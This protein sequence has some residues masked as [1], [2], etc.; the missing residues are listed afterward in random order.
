M[1]SG[2]TAMTA[3]GFGQRDA[4]DV[5]FYSELLCQAQF[6]ADPNLPNGRAAQ[7]A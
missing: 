5:H 4:A 2:V 3:Q 1:D 7:S 6:G